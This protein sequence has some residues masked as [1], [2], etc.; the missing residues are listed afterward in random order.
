[1]GANWD[2]PGNVRPPIRNLRGVSEY[3][4]LTQPQSRPASAGRSSGLNPRGAL[5][6]PI[7][8][9]RE[10]LGGEARSGSTGR[11]DLTG[12]GV[13]PFA[14]AAGDPQG[15]RTSDGVGYKKVS[16]PVSASML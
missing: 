14:L 1:M 9:A 6:R 2:Q 4:P 12:A 16:G 3:T 13:L 8:C 7:V 11:S 10:A 5:R 15:W